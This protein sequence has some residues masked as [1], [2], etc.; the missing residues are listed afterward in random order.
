MRFITHLLSFAIFLGL[1]L[2]TSVEIANAAK[3]PNRT[4]ST[5]L[6]EDLYDDYLRFHNETRFLEVDIPMRPITPATTESLLMFWI[7]G[8]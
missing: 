8:R 3:D 7:M 1:N 6:S 2:L 4:L 5:M